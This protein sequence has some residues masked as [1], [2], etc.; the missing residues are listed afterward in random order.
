[1]FTKQIVFAKQTVQL[2]GTETADLQDDP[3]ILGMQEL[4][5]SVCC[6]RKTPLSKDILGTDQSL[7]DYH[8]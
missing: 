2:M 6:R 5:Y 4:T 7:N 1:M 8:L 3:N